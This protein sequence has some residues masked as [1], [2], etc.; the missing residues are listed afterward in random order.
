MN[1]CN[2]DAGPLSVSQA[3]CI[4]FS[5]LYVDATPIPWLFMSSHSHICDIYHKMHNLFSSCV[6]V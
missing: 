6:F 4:L 1:S 2:G 3:I 5:F